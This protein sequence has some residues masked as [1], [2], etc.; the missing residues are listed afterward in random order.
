MSTLSTTRDAG[1]T[2]ADHAADHNTLHTAF[3]NQ[4]LFLPVRAGAISAPAVMTAEYATFPNAGTGVINYGRIVLPDDWASLHV[5][6]LW[7]QLAASAG[8]MHWSLNVTQ[9][10]KATGS[11]VSNPS[12]SGTVVSPNSTTVWNRDRIVTSHAIDPVN[13]EVQ[14]TFTRAGGDASDTITTDTA[15]YGLLLTKAA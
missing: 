11:T 13:N 15:L 6:I 9:R 8:N 12:T 7:M 14:F 1:S 3:N 2:P 10:T 4:A 5:D